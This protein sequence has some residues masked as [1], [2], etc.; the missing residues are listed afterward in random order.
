M[1]G[2]LGGLGVAVVVTALVLVA[3]LAVHAPAQATARTVRRPSVRAARSAALP[4]ADMMSKRMYRARWQAPPG[5]LSVPRDGH[6]FARLDTSRYRL[7][8]VFDRMNCTRHFRANDRFCVAVYHVTYVRRTDGTSAGGGACGVGVS[9]YRTRRGLRTEPA[10]IRRTGYCLPYPGTRPALQIGGLLGASPVV[11]HPAPPSL[12][13]PVLPSGLRPPVTDGSMPP[14]I[15]DTAHASDLYT[16]LGAYV[17][18][19]GPYYAAAGFWF[20]VRWYDFRGTTYYL[21]NRLAYVAQF[22]YAY[23]GYRYPWM[24]QNLIQ[25]TCEGGTGWDWAQT[26]PTC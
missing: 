24:Q 12:P 21:Y 16:D 6:G 22:Y 26:V 17:G 9:V 1:A 20:Y 8:G 18:Y 13:T 19:Q 10:S 11:V 4:V 2:R 7:S 25:G 5:D 14:A 3:A 15:A 23:N